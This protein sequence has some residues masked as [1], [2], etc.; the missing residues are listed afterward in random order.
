MAPCVGGGRGPGQPAG[1]RA[2]HT[3]TLLGRRRYDKKPGQGEPSFSPGPCGYL[4][5]PV[6]AVG[7]HIAV[8]CTEECGL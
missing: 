6:D 4:R 3:A 8:A 1:F 5:R 7:F 2:A